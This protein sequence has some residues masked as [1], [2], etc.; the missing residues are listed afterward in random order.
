MLRI[1][2]LAAALASSGPALAHGWGGHGGGGHWGGQGG[3][4][5]GGHGGGG[6][7]HGGRWIP[8]AV[9]GGALL[10]GAAYCWR[11]DPYTGQMVWVCGGDW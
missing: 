7:W 10:G 2:F 3:W 5:G 8:W 9:G 4:H 6:H 11:S 1:I